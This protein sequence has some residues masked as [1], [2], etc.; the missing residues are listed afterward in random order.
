MKIGK[1]VLLLAYIL[2]GGALLVAGVFALFCWIGSYS[3]RQ[4][5]MMDHFE[6]TRLKNGLPYYV[7]NCTGTSRLGSL[8]HTYHFGPQGI[9]K[10]ASPPE[11]FVHTVLILGNCRT[12]G[13]VG[14]EDANETIPSAIEADLKKRGHKIR[15]INA[16]MGTGSPF[17][18]VQKLDELL[19]EFKPSVILFFTTSFDPISEYFHRSEYGK[20]SIISYFPL[21]LQSYVYRKTYLPSTLYQ[22]QYIYTLFKI[23]FFEPHEELIDLVGES[24]DAIKNLGNRQGIPVFFVQTFTSVAVNPEGYI[25]DKRNPEKKTAPVFLFAATNLIVKLIPSY[26]SGLIPKYD[27][28]IEGTGSAI[29]LDP[30]GKSGMDFFELF[31]GDH[32]HIMN[33]RLDKIVANDVADLIAQKLAHKKQRRPH[34]AGAK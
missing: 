33:S 32:T 1:T 31:A 23:R 28:R 2:T 25:F 13:F 10:T 29:Q 20:K 27:A 24:L 30:I 7:P 16:S 5:L 3:V 34:R 17:Q 4:G 11:D 19:A 26:F 21:K 12:S 15:I 6:C 8:T 9:I 18:T 14:E 22:L